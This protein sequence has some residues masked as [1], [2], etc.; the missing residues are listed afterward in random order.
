MTASQRTLPPD[1]D[2]TDCQWCQAVR[3]GTRFSDPPE[4]IPPAPNPPVQVVTFGCVHEHFHDAPVCAMHAHEIATLEGQYRAIQCSQCL[5]VG[6][7]ADVSVVE[8]V[9][10]P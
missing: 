6:F 9:D 3:R 5:L 1:L 10:L 8:K 7:A 4:A 2:L